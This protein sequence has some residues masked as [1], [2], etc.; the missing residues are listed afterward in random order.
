MKATPATALACYDAL[1]QVSMHVRHHL[2]GVA[3]EAGLTPPQ[4]RVL[5]LLSAPMRMQAAAEASGCEPSHITGIAD[6][7]EAAGLAG[8][9]PDPS[10]RRARLLFLTSHGQR[11]RRRLLPALVGT[12]PVVSSLDESDQAELLRLLTRAGRGV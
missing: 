9:E 4:A 3:H 12:A 11:L 6:Q 10:D 8:R 7:L 1:L 2:E 5:L